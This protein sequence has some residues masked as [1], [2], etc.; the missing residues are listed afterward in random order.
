MWTSDIWKE[1][2][3]FEEKE[4]VTIQ[5]FLSRV[6]SDDRKIVERSIKDA[7]NRV[8]GFI[9]QH[10]IVL[11]DGRER[12][13]SKTGR[14]QLTGNNGTLRVLSVALDIT[15]QVLAETTTHELSSRIINAQEDERKRIARDLHDDLNQRLAVLSMETDR[16]GR[17]ETA[18]SAQSLIYEIA[19]QVRSLS[20]EIHTLSYNSSRQT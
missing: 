17:M 5:N 12:W 14:V 13:I 3:G 8:G 7:V 11:P 9:V 4:Q 1:I 18:P 19:T 20:T 10:R 16:L 2:N 6:H 15:E